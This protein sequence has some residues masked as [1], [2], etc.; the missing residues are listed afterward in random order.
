MLV[1]AQEGKSYSMFMEKLKVLKNFSKSSKLGT[2]TAA[3]T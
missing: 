1:Q 3:C 2:R